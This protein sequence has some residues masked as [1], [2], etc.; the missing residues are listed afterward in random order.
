MTVLFVLT[1]WVVLA[2]VG[3]LIMSAIG[4]AA[5]SDDDMTATGA[6]APSRTLV[7]PVR[8]APR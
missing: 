6:P 3:A 8:E 2:I 7:A 5:S 1:S 4:R